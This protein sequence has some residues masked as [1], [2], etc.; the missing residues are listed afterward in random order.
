M[1]PTLLR[2][3]RITEVL[4]TLQ[5]EPYGWLSPGEQLRLQ[6]LQVES[7]RDQY[8]SGHWLVRCLLAEQHGGDPKDW[9]LEERPSLPPAVIG[10]EDDIHL[11]L[12][13]SADWIAA[14]VSSAPIGI[15]IEQRHPPREALHRFEHLLLAEGE[16]PGTL[17][18]DELLQRWVVKEAW[19]KQHH[20]SALPDQLTKLALRRCDSGNAQ[21]RLFASESVL[22]AIATKSASGFS[23]GGQF[24]NDASDWSIDPQSD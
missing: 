15:D 23:A 19:I 9:A 8:L 10:H 2:V 11:S 16:T 22:L 18:T 5:R 17:N 7:R 24:C 1:N 6:R 3:A 13:H 20:G 21:L 4:A 14:A 12:S